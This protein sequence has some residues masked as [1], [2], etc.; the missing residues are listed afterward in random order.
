[1][2]KKNLI[3]QKKENLMKQKKNNAWIFI[4]LMIVSFIISVVIYT[5]IV[6]K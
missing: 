3:K 5:G 4:A 6:L 1:M 2:E